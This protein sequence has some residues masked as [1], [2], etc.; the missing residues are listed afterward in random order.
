MS[1]VPESSNSL[2]VVPGQTAA[3]IVGA[4]LQTMRPYQWLKNLLVFVPLAASHRL[5]EREL[6]CN[7]AYLFVAF[8]LCASSVYVFN[9]LQDVPADRLHPHKRY[10]PIASGALPRSIAIGLVPVLTYVPGMI[11]LSVRKDNGPGHFDSLYLAAAIRGSASPRGSRHEDR[12][13][14][15]SK[16]TAVTRLPIPEIEAQSDG[17][18]L[19][20]WLRASRTPSRNNP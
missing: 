14:I 7:T 18:R 5:G 16:I 17:R 8:S 1:A 13:A 4:V 11:C 9:D 10:R 12:R 2:S 15:T 20:S 3:S 19:L 6:L